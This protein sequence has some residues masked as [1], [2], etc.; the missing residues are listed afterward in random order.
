M[1]GRDE[2]FLIGGAGGGA[3][4]LSMPYPSSTNFV[5]AMGALECLSRKSVVFVTA[6]FFAETALSLI[7]ATGVFVLIKFDSSI[8]DVFAYH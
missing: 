3:F 7:V 6:E 8:L 5:F 1:L 4:L 2:W